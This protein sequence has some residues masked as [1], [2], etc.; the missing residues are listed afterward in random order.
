MLEKSRNCST[1]SAVQHSISIFLAFLS[2]SSLSTVSL[3]VVGNPDLFKTAFLVQWY[4]SYG[5]HQFWYRSFP[6]YTYTYILCVLRTCLSIELQ[7]HYVDI[8]ILMPDDKKK[9]NS[10][11]VLPDAWYDN[12][13]NDKGVSALQMLTTSLRKGWRQ[14]QLLLHNLQA[15][16]LPENH[17]IL[18]GW[19]NDL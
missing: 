3:L 5:F 10:W 6:W 8:K 11:W 16:W 15:G 12:A 18:S 17:Q 2:R 19:V 7:N 13:N 1:V 4:Q 9:E 14:K